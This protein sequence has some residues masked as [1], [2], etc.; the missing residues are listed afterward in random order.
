MEKTKLRIYFAHPIGTYG[1]A[2]ESS[3]LN[4]IRSSFGSDDDVELEIVNPGDPSVQ[5]RYEKWLKEGMKPDDHKMRFFKDLV[6]S[7]DGVVYYGDT[8]G[9]RYELD[10]ARE[11]EIPVIDV[12]KL[13]K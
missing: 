11:E 9:V 4:R 5:K 6:L 2:R 10:K 3:S 7:C 12:S 1:T 13:G 8:P